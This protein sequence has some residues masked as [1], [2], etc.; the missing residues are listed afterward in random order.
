MQL[1]DRVSIN[2]EG[3][4]QDRLAALA[5]KKNYCA[6][7]GLHRRQYPVLSKAGPE[8]PAAFW[9]IGT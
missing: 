2:L 7:N 6:P 9:G 3:P 1:A 5:P 8:H 4:T